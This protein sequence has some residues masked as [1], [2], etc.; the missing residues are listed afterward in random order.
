[1]M[2]E[3]N[4]LQTNWENVVYTTIHILNEAHLKL[5]Y[6]KTPYELWHNKPTFITQ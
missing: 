3:R 6:D 4:I 2:Q 5:N 1:M